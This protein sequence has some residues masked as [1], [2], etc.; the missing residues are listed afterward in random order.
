MDAHD[1]INY[2]TEFDLNNPYT[3]NDKEIISFLDENDD[4]TNNEPIEEADNV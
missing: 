1:F 4:A 2:E 3:P